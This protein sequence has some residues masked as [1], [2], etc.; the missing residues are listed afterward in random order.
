MELGDLPAHQTIVLEGCDGAG[1][2]TLATRLASGYGFAVVHSSRTPD[3]IDLAE[4]YRQ[5]L[6]RPGRLALDRSF[7]SELVYGPLR[8]GASRLS[9][10]EARDLAVAVAR[11]D[12]VLV[13]LIAP[14]SAI[15]ARLLARDGSAAA[16]LADIKAL[17]AAYERVVTTFAPYLPVWTLE[18]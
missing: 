18:T 16:N 6:A 4:R 3:G 8:H 14:A 1:K 13:H 9:D 17:L 15:R 11:R 7:I 10:V 5:I 12:G 2:S